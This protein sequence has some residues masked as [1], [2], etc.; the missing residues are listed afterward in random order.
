MWPAAANLVEAAVDAL[1][2]RDAGDEFRSAR[3]R[4]VRCAPIGALSSPF[5]LAEALSGSVDLSLKLER[6]AS[7][8]HE[9]REG[10]RRLQDFAA[11]HPTGRARAGRAHHRLLAAG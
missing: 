7:K 2:L 10:P 8:L 11:T 4:A 6:R 5:R 3:Y 9:H 1:E